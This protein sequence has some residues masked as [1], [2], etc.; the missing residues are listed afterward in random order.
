M[1]ANNLDLNLED[2]PPPAY[3]E[4]EP[5][6][7]TQR[8]PNELS[9]YFPAGNFYLAE[10]LSHPLYSLRVNYLNVSPVDAEIILGS[11]P[12]PHDP[13]YATLRLRAGSE[14]RVWAPKLTELDFAAANM[15]FSGPGGLFR[16]G[17]G[18]CL[19]TVCTGSHVEEFEWRHSVVP[20]VWKPVSAWKLIR[21]AA[22]SGVAEASRSSQGA[23]RSDEE[24]VATV[25]FVRSRSKILTI[26]FER[27]G[28]TGELGESWAVMTI[29]SALAIHYH[30]PASLSTESAEGSSGGA[31]QP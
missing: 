7:G 31:A 28:S 17:A 9:L 6:R 22:P 1:S 3:S 14:A 21:K 27:S 10:H 5:S 26:K 30:R 12:E 13:L 4:T 8:I 11:G 18:T 20:D 24:T 19:F 25:S 2:E 29:L 23:R 15:T 16:T